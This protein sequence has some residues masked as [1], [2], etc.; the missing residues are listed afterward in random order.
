M[1]M[2]ADLVD[3]E[4]ILR[5]FNAQKNNQYAL[6]LT[7][8][9][10]RKAKLRKLQEAVEKTWRQEI[11]DALKKDFGKPQAE[12]DMT[13]IYPV[14]SEIKHAVSHLDEWLSNQYVKTP[15]AFLGSSSYIKYEPKGVC[16][17]LSPWNFPINLC[18]GPLVSAIAAGNAVIIKPSEYTV[19]TSA[20]MKSSHPFF[21]RMKCA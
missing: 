13:E 21:R 10:E 19:Q 11:R 20:L 8:A 2:V 18:F 9:K 14:T 16:L 4:I 6:G 3:S 17:I 12:V 15:M 7:T 1:N 5:V